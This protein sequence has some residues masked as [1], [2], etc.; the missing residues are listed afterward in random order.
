MKSIRFSQHAEANLKAREIAREDA[1]TAIRAP[2]RREAAR[3]PREL[4]STPPPLPH[5]PAP[6]V[7][8]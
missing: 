8:R 4:C 3:P 6:Q 1:E 7:R 5:L 2:A